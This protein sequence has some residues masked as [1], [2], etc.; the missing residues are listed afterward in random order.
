MVTGT[1]VVIAELTAV[2]VNVTVP[3]RHIFDAKVGFPKLS[4]LPQLDCY[5]F[6][7]LICARYEVGCVMQYYCGRQTLALY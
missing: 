5:Y 3:G 4:K 6:P 1:G 2:A 7:H